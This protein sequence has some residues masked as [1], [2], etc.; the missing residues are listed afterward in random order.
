VTGGT[1]RTLDDSGRIG[2]SLYIDGLLGEPL[3]LYPLS[4]LF[5]NLSFLADIFTTL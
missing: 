1:L 5:I 4:L 2:T 3:S